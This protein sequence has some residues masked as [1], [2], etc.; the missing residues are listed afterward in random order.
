MDNTHAQRQARYRERQKA[1]HDEELAQAK[2]RIAELE[3]ALK[4][5]QASRDAERKEASRDAVQFELSKARARIAELENALKRAQ[6]SRDAQAS[7][8]P[9]RDAELDRLKAANRNLR[10]KLAD[11]ERW[12]KDELSRDGK[13]PLPTFRAIM[14][15]LHPDVTPSD[16]EREHAC[17]LFNVYFDAAKHRR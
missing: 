10:A 8:S 13:M 4:Q 11:M 14:K 12:Y 5:A 17:K 15:C 1:K 6:A 7:S 9:S 2:G 3:R 16:E